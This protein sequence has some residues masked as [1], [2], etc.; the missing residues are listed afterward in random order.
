[1][2][3]Y[4]VLS[5]S[6]FSPTSKDAKL[7]VRPS[8]CLYLFP[9]EQLKQV[10]YCHETSAKRRRRAFSLFLSGLSVMTCRALGSHSVRAGLS[11]E[12][13][14]NFLAALSRS[15]VLVLRWLFNHAEEQISFCW[16]F[17]ERAV[18]PADQKNQTQF[19]E[20]SG[21][22]AGPVHLI[23]PHQTQRARPSSLNLALVGL[24]QWTT[25]SFTTRTNQRSP[26]TGWICP[27]R[28]RDLKM[29]D[30]LESFFFPYHPADLRHH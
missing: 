19:I 17:W 6:R 14:S 3:G 10:L 28:H 9:T 1:M 30:T 27:L 2:F 7:I 15:H 22:P 5:T 18:R 24:D 26:A 11:N 20:L 12:D 4:S 25:T 23:L 21:C 13:L 29:L 16:L 8:A